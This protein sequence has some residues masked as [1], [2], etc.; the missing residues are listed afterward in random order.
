MVSK[1][2]PHQVG[3]AGEHFVAGEILRRGGHASTFAGNMPDIDVLAADKQQD[4]TAWIQ[5]K[6]KRSGRSW[7]TTTARGEERHPERD[8]VRFWVLVDLAS[9]DPEYYIVPEWWMANDIHEAHTSYLERHG[10]QRARSKDSTHHA[11]PVSRVAEWR[12]RWDLL[13]IFDG[14]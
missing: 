10:G 14:V 2:T 12:G 11:I 3:R 1:P 9:G 7:Q 5:V 13:G 4:R 6:T 8:P